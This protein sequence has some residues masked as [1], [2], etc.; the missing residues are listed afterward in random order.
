MLLK[1][2]LGTVTIA[3]AVGINT[4]ENIKERI[5]KMKMS[6]YFSATAIQFIKLKVD[7]RGRRKH[8]SDFSQ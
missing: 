3:I 4:S 8:F 6:K 2:W 7:V 1:V 5:K